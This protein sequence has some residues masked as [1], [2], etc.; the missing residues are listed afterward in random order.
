MSYHA[1]LLPLTPLGSHC[2]SF[3]GSSIL[4]GI[5]SACQLHHK[6]NH[7]YD[8]RLTGNQSAT[9]FQQLCMSPR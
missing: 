2:E 4:T 7:T 9:F 8:S 6:Q 3:V 1:I 5:P